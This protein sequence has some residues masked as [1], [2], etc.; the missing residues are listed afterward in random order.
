MGYRDDFY[1]VENIIGITGPVDALPTVYFEDPV[2]YE[3]GHITQVHMADWNQG[4]TRVE[5]DPGYK[6]LNQC[7]GGCMCQRHAAHEFNGKGECIH[8]SRSVFI[9]R[10]YL[11]KDEMAVVCQAIWRCPHMKTDPETSAGR[12]RQQAAYNKRWADVEKKGRRHG[13]NFTALGLANRVFQ[14][15]YPSRVK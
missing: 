8:P 11:T 9:E 2:F 1:T 15:I 10:K 4:R 6:I 3:F 5:M 13:V 7:G 12:R 14:A